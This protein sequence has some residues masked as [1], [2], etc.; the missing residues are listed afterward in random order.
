M[1][2]PT[3][4]LTALA[5]VFS[6]PLTLSAQR[7]GAPPK[8]KAKTRVQI[9]LDENGREI[10]RDTVKVDP[11]EAEARALAE[12]ARKLAEETRQQADAARARADVLRS[13]ADSLRVNLR[14]EPD[15]QLRAELSME[16]RRAMEE[17]ERAL[18]ELERSHRMRELMGAHGRTFDF[19]FPSEFRMEMPRI[20]SWEMHTPDVN[21]MHVPRA[22]RVPRAPMRPG[23]RL[24]IHAGPETEVDEK[25]LSNDSTE[26]RQYTITRRK[27]QGADAFSFG[28]HTWSPRVPNVVKLRLEDNRKKA[29][30]WIKLEGGQH[31]ITLTDAAGKVLLTETVNGKGNFERD[32]K[33]PADARKPLT[34]EVKR[35]DGER[36]FNYKVTE[37]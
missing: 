12:E 1:N 9:T 22:P 23:Q 37:D 31:V 27:G 24:W 14:E 18:R 33:L 30:I 28:P 4:L 16:L 7:D 35:T 11:R 2:R 15:A 13:R 10:G 26:I 21:G 36:T 17:S 29:Q 34:L 19:R 20:E 3:A 25:D 5:L 32:V 6:A 8:A